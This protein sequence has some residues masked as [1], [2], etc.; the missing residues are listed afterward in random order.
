MAPA[1]D[2]AK[3]RGGWKCGRCGCAKNKWHWS[4]CKHCQRSWTG[5]AP[6]DT[7][8]PQWPLPKPKGGKGK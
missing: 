7:K 5:V 4:W 1:A 2:P 6:S 3:P 8:V